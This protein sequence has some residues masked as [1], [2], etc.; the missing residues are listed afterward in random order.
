MKLYIIRHGETDWN[1]ARRVQGHSDIPLNDYGRNLAKQTAE[2]LKDTKFDLAYTSPL[3]RAKETAKI[4][5][6]GREIPLLEE[7]GI[8]ELGFGVYEGMCISG[9]KKAPE[10]EE[11]NRF[12]KDTANYVPAEGGESI[13][14]LMD[15]TGAF[16]KRICA[17]ETL[18][19]KAILISTHG[20]AMTALLNNIKG[21][22]EIGRFWNQGVPANCAVTVVEAEHGNLHITAEN[23]IYY[24][25][26]VKKWDVE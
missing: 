15:R 10:S 21:I 6:R 7:E 8:K 16:M 18:Y 11:F 17:D 5:L 2:G 24:K 26:P 22:H 23:L 13:Q 12:F 20:A 25:E 14:E 9:S 1:K 4:I 19:D 3:V